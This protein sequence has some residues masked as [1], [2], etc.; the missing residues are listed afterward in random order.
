LIKN[1]PYPVSEIELRN[2]LAIV[3][4][5]W[6]LNR[7]QP[8]LIAAKVMIEIKKSKERELRGLR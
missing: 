4:E 2:A 5:R 3:K 1:I 7:L 6:D 8:W